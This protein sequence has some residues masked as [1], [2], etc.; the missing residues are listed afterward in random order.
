MSESVLLRLA[1]EEMI[2]LL[3]ALHLTDFPGLDPEPLKDLADRQKSLLMSEA[4]HTLRARGLVRW[5][6]ETEREIDPLITQV[7]LECTAPRYTLFVDTLVAKTAMAKLLYIFGSEV[8]VEQSEPEPQVQQYLVMPQRADF[9]QRLH[10]LLAQPQATTF[11]QLPSGQLHL[12]LWQAALKVAR[13]DEARART[14]LAASLP[15][16]TASALAAATHDVQSLQYLAL[17][18]KVPNAE[19]PYPERALTIVVGH[20]Q[21][22]LLWQ[23]QSESASLMVMPVPVEHIWE[24]VMRLIPPN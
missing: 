21:C 2:Y 8:I 13:T 1:N 11:T 20:G 7:L 5:R 14:I 17:W 15:A 12:D 6:S 10:T 16:P 19:Q 4:D 3:R 23:D 9:L 24:H 22:I 18:K